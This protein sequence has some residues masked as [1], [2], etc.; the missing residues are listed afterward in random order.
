MNKFL[1]S[2]L[3]LLTCAM[4]NAQ[5]TTT[6][7]YGWA[8]PNPQVYVVPSCVSKI[9][10]IARGASGCD[11]GATHSAGKGAH[12]EGTFDVNPG[13]SIEIRV[14][15]N[16]CSGFSNISY[17]G[18]TGGGGGTYVVKKKNGVYTPLAIAGGGGGGGSY[19][20]TMKHGQAS[21]TAGSG[22]GG[23]SGVA[24]TNGEGGSSTYYSGS[25]AGFLTNG[26]TGSNANMGGKS[27]MNGGD[28]GITSYY[29]G[30]FG[31][32]GAG[33]G[34]YSGGGGGGYNGGGGAGADGCGGGGSSYNDGYDKNDS[35]GVNAGH[36]IVKI[37]AYNAE[38]DFNI[39]YSLSHVVC[40][41][42]SDGKVVVTVNGDLSPYRYNFDDFGFG[43]SNTYSDIEP[44]EHFLVVRDACM[45]YSDTV[46]FTINE[47]AIALSFSVNKVPGGNDSSGSIEVIAQGGEAPYS[48]SLNNG[49]L[50]PD[51]FWD[52]LANGTY[53]V[54]VEDSRGCIVSKNVTLSGFASNNEFAIPSIRVFPNPASNVIN[55]ANET[56]VKYTLL[57]LTG[58]TIVENNNFVL[59]HIIAVENLEKGIYLLKLTTENN[60]VSSVKVVVN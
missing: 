27:Y 26:G 11:A 40:K 34:S 31:G 39:T 58:K 55:I 54:L 23:G 38:P 19:N 9:K 16:P 28:G 59:S 43:T 2:S 36:G 12:I 18:G 15:Q 50:G 10:I 21:T 44:G 20:N 53:F 33:L 37:T 7:T 4:V 57:D 51:N 24:G 47:P 56:P 32:G 45:N 6:F 48:Y 35:T 1:V 30:G 5:N 29:R 13:D 22:E 14:G 8:A 25:G 42:E 41:G 52:S 46:F 3:G 17:N 49:I 60:I